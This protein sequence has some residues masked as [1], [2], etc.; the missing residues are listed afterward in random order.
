[1]QESKKEN[2]YLHIELYVKD[3]RTELFSREFKSLFLCLGRPCTGFGLAFHHNKDSKCAYPVKR[4]IKIIVSHLLQTFFLLHLLCLPVIYSSDSS[5]LK[6]KSEKMIIWKISSWYYFEFVLSHTKIR[7]GVINSCSVLHKP[8]LFC[9]D[10]V[11]QGPFSSVI[12]SQS[13]ISL[14]F[15]QNKIRIHILFSFFVF[16]RVKQS[17]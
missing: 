17:F 8:M 16:W 13:K 4:K 12:T 10:L 3:E 6:R 11:L 2:L 7:G 5:E 9:K 15:I 1:M 14:S